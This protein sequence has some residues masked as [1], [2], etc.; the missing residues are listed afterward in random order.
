MNILFIK[1]SIPRPDQFAGDRRCYAVL[2]ILS[3]NHTIDFFA[4]E[5]IDKL[6]SPD[7]ERYIELLKDIKVNLFFSKN[8]KIEGLLTRSRYDICI[9]VFYT[10][11]EEYLA[12]FRKYQPDSMAI[13]DTV[14][15]HFEREELAA[16]IGLISRETVEKNKKKELQIYRDVNGVIVVTERERQLLLKEKGISSI[17]V[18]PIIIETVRRDE[19]LR[20][21]EL[22]FVG[23]YAWQP[24]V[25]GVLW[26][27]KDI[28]PHIYRAV[29]DAVFSVVGSNPTAEINNLKDVPGINVVGYVPDTAPFLN[30]AAISI[31]P[32]RFGGGMKG[33]VNE[34]MAYG[35]P[36][37]TTS[38]GA[39][40]FDARSGEH[41]IIEDDTIKFAQA[42]IDL[43]NDPQK[44]R[45]IGLAG[46]E[47][48][49][50]ICSPEVAAM[51]LAEMI[52]DIEKLRTKE[53]RKEDPHIQSI[54][55]EMHAKLKRL[56]AEISQKDSMILELKNSIS[57]KLAAPI[58]AAYDIVHGTYNDEN[59]S[60]ISKQMRNLSKFKNE[61]AI[62]ALKNK[63]VGEIGFIIGNGPSVRLEDLEKL[64]DKITFCAN[65]FYLAY[66]TMKFRPEYTVVCD[67]QV[68]KDYGEEIIAKSNGTKI[69]F[70]DDKDQNLPKIKGKHIALRRREPRPMPFSTDPADFVPSGGS[71]I[72][73]A[74]QMAFYMG[75]RTI[76]LY[77]IDHNFKY[78]K[79]ETK[80]IWTSAKGDDNH[81][82]KNYRNGKNWCPPDLKYIEDSFLECR[83]FLEKNGAVI[84]NATRGGKLEIFE[85]IDFDEAYK[86]IEQANKNKL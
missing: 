40:G 48:N 8:E 17:Y 50:S 22:V 1:K 4:T 33:K 16:N 84:K 38:V 18:V 46:Q 39:Q 69:V 62:A 77:G 20:Q 14:D 58:R 43:L 83:K 82:I 72:V 49:S 13:V 27:A 73:A 21:K 31:A 6:P 79:V 54:Q 42:C 51:K 61:R 32:L 47:L 56:E 63:H 11:T 19:S 71:V 35:V 34:A 59:D 80:D 3:K 45:R 55:R 23:G 10:I 67:N 44:Q 2:K 25:D 68:I 7:R 52:A 30:R 85:R 65:R 37:V 28:W 60:F 53:I 70:Y 75:I 78:Q 74:I 81:F 26:F 24:N 5:D 57:W 76:Y 41:L 36:V 64:K 29:P 9:F 66:N 86:S 15:L 12:T